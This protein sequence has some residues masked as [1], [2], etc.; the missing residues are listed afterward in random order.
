MFITIIKIQ[1][2]IIINK[3]SKINFFLKLIYIFAVVYILYNYSQAGRFLIDYLKTHF[4]ENNPYYYEISNILFLMLTLAN[5]LSVFLFGSVSTLNRQLRYFPTA[6]S[7]IVVNEIFAGLFDIVNLFYTAIYFSSLFYNDTF[8]W[9]SFSESF[10]IFILFILSISNMSYFIK[11]IVALYYKVKKKWISFS[12]FLLLIILS[13]S[14]NFSNLIRN[15]N[16]IKLSKLIGIFPSGVY[17]NAVQSTPGLSLFIKSLLYFFLLNGALLYLNIYLTHKTLNK[18]NPVRFY[19]NHM[20]KYLSLISLLVNSSFSTLGKKEIL[21]HLRSIK[22]KFIYTAILFLYPYML[23]IIIYK[24]VTNNENDLILGLTLMGCF[25]LI[26]SLLPSNGNLFKFGRQDLKSSFVF[27]ISLKGLLVSK[28][29]VGFLSIL[30]SVFYTTIALFYSGISFIDYICYISFLIIAYCLFRNLFILL[31]IYFPK[32][33]NVDKINGL[34]TSFKTLII[35]LPL[36][37]GYLSLMYYFY[38]FENTIL[39]TVLLS[40]AVI[41]PFIFYKFRIHDRLV[42]IF[43]E[44]KYIIIESI[45]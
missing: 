23:F 8:Y 33:I 29:I 37:L 31:S 22:Y 7:K 16:I 45:L 3:F 43:S 32:K 27:P 38:L 4:Q 6:L 24:S 14:F 19:D 26:S 20:N 42:K 15:I 30:T 35:S 21:F 25:F 40:I 2:K 12:L 17:F 5:F 11:T 9:T 1:T 44:R 36:M 41:L 28:E 10:I 18:K 13:F 34:T 39:I